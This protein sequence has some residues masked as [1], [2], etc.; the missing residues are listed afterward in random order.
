MLLAFGSCNRFEI[1]STIKPSVMA[2]K[3]F[4]NMKHGIDP[5]KI[6]EK[7]FCGRLIE[8]YTDIVGSEN[9]RI[10]LLTS[11]SNNVYY[12]LKDRKLFDEYINQRGFIVNE[13]DVKDYVKF[14]YNQ[15]CF[16][17][18]NIVMRYVLND[19][20]EYNEFII[21]HLKDDSSLIQTGNDLLSIDSLYVVNNSYN[22]LC[23]LLLFKVENKE[24]IS[25]TLDIINVAVTSRG[26]IM[27][28][29]IS[30]IYNKRIESKTIIY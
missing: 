21:D 12:N 1:S 18:S 29:N 27:Y 24:N 14:Y 25:V 6:M 5:V 10:V 2:A 4:L 22:Y 17:D 11:D 8:Y 28:S 20:K 16:A 19:Q 23:Y 9:S 15:L 13:N 3:H 7:V 26:N 30:N